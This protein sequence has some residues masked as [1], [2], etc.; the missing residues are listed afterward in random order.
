[1]PEF[2]FTLPEHPSTRAVEHRGYTRYLNEMTVRMTR[3]V[4]AKS[5]FFCLVKELGGTIMLWE[6]DDYTTQAA[7]AGFTQTEIQARLE[8]L[9]PAI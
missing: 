4:P 9:Y 1:M 3:D 7:G 2:S 5:Q 8:A 6:G